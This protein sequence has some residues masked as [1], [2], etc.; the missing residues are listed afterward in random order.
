MSLSSDQGL[1]P[2][3]NG[4]GDVDQSPL[5]SY[6]FGAPRTVVWFDNESTEYYVN[7]SV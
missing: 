4:S 7:T 5:R 1:S 2:W 6:F 3:L